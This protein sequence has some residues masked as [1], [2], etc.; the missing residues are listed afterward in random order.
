MKKIEL[1]N[2]P[3]C[4]ERIGIQDIKCPY[5][6]YIDDPK[7]KRH[8]DRLGKNK[9]KKYKYTKK[10]DVFKII[11]LIPIVFYLMYLIYDF[12][13]LKIILPLILLNVLCLFVKKSKIMVVIMLE[14]SLF[15]FNFIRNIYIMN[16]NNDF[17]N[18]KYEIIIFVFA[19]LFI[20][21]PKFIYCI[22]KT[23]IRKKKKV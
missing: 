19:V 21:V 14:I 7:Y 3:N 18:I 15:V 12:N 22:K 2:C 10:N 4:H 13:L 20:V 11:F 8:N 17:S 1:K 23:K 16:S 5:C 9:S 6:K